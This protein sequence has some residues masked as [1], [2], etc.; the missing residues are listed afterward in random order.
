MTRRITLADGF[1]SG[2]LRVYLTAYK[3]AGSNILVYYKLLSQSDPDDFDDKE[4]QLMTEIGNSNFISINYNDYRE[5][6]FAPGLEGTESNQV[7]Y[8]SGST[9]YRSFRTFAIKVVLTG[10]SFV[11]VPKVRDFRAIALPEGS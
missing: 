1:E 6:T 7:S 2:D 8:S 5:L 9:S 3:P 10:T 11:D 4:Y